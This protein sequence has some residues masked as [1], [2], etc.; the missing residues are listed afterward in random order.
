MVASRFF[1]EKAGLMEEDYFLYYE[2]VDWAFCRKDLPILLAP[3]ALV[4]H[5][6]GTSIGTGSVV[7]LASPFANYFNF[8][9]RIRFARR[10][11]QWRLPI[12]YLGALAIGVQLFLKGGTSEAWALVCGVFNLR[13]P[14]DVSK[15]ISDKSA[16]KL[17]FGRI[18]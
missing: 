9:N 6:G 5:H 4:Y 15:R 11:L 7:R 8:R 18:E 1:I 10:H 12:V 13:P 3:D 17:A 2:E 14:R 16:R